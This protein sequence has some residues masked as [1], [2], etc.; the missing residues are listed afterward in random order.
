MS[1]FRILTLARQATAIAVVGTN[2]NLSAI[3]ATLKAAGLKVLFSFKEGVAENV[4][5]MKEAV[6]AGNAFINDASIDIWN[7]TQGVPGLLAKGFD[8]NNEFSLFFSVSKKPSSA[9]P[10]K[11]DWGSTIDLLAPLFV[12]ATAAMDDQDDVDSDD[13]DDDG[14]VDTS[15]TPVQKA[16]NLLPKTAGLFKNPQVREIIANYMVNKNIVDVDTLKNSASHAIAMRREIPGNI[17]K[18]FGDKKIVSDL[19]RNWI[20]DP[21]KQEIEEIFLSAIKSNN[22]EGQV[23]QLL[24]EHSMSTAA[25]VNAA[26]TSNNESDKG[27]RAKLFNA[28]DKKFGTFLNI[29]NSLCLVNLEDTGN[30]GSNTVIDPPVMPSPQ[31]KTNTVTNSGS[32]TTVNEFFHF[33]GK[34]KIRPVA[35]EFGNLHGEFR[36]NFRAFPPSLTAAIIDFKGAHVLDA[37]KVL[38]P[39]EEMKLISQPGAIMALNAMV[40]PSK[41]GSHKSIC[42][43]ET[44]TALWLKANNLSVATLGCSTKEKI[45]ELGYHA[46]ELDSIMQTRT[47]DLFVALHSVASEAHDITVRKMITEDNIIRMVVDIAINEFGLKAE[48][49]QQNTENEGIMDF[50]IVADLTMTSSFKRTLTQLCDGAIANAAAKQHAETAGLLNDLRN[51][52]NT[53]KK[54]DRDRTNNNNNHNNNDKNKDGGR[55]AKRGLSESEKLRTI[56]KNNFKDLQFAGRGAP[57]WEMLPKDA[58]IL[59]LVAGVSGLEHKHKTK[60]YRYNKVSATVAKAKFNNIEAIVEYVKKNQSA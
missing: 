60:N 15:N 42:E 52:S 36:Q 5:S 12:Q 4:N 54:R 20:V 46:F 39:Q 33:Q 27:F 16:M 47:K 10:D 45:A 40:M 13:S 31:A 57:K 56:I 7:G 6:I 55:D 32:K 41:K 25:D 37:M 18:Q 30:L 9:A 23:V 51:E 17:I 44:D 14:N 35:R 11:F 1:A 22:L 28:L 34:S 3:T 38:D 24:N 48:G 53:R 49:F 29:V 50:N 19:I 58:C 26:M 21:S 59:C 43:R 2:E 8:N